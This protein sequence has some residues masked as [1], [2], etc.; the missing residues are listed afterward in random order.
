MNLHL[1]DGVKKTTK[2]GE[3]IIIN[4]AR[5]KGVSIAGI[6][7]SHQ[8]LEEYARDREMTK[9]MQNC[10][11]FERLSLEQSALIGTVHQR[12]SSVEMGLNKKL[13]LSQM[14]IL[15]SRS[16]EPTMVPASKI[17]LEQLKHQSL[18]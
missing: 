10:K 8:V 12:R 6:K 15:R 3:S 9:N 7:M 1:V 14:K 4:E 5:I 17:N 18:D 13:Q 2:K 16:P 11:P